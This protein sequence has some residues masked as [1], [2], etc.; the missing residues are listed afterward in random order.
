MP[1]E[2][3]LVVLLAVAAAAQDAKSASD[4]PIVSSENIVRQLTR[5]T[6]R[7]K[8]LVLVDDEPAS[9][10]FPNIEFV[11]GSAELSPT[12]IAQL[13]ELGKALAA[14]ALTSF[15]FEIAGHTDATGSDE[16]N[17]SLSLRRARS[18]QT[19]LVEVM[20]VAPERLNISGYGEDRLAVPSDP[21]A[22]QNRRVEIINLG[23]N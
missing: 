9:I 1:A 7:D 21:D 20:A 13:E 5:S 10:S 19:Y 17:Q 6:D 14:S 2:V 18:V 3:T 11:K 4:A 12:A 22:A 23:T 8:G 16:F 15:R